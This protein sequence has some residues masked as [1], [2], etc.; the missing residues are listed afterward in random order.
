[1]STPDSAALGY[2]DAAF[3]VSV[4]ASW[5]DLAHDDEGIA[6]VYETAAAIEPYSV[7]AAAPTTCRPTSPRP[8]ARRLRPRLIR[9]PPIPQIPLRPGKRPAPQPERPA[10]GLAS[11]STPSQKSLRATANSSLADDA[12]LMLVLRA[13]GRPEP[14]PR[15]LRGEHQAAIVLRQQ[16]GQ[17]ELRQ[18]FAD[19]LGALD[20][21]LPDP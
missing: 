15:N 1:M 16:H 20:V 3:N 17:V 6:W 4:M 10:G 7:S 5:T 21:R 14:R 12:R 2:R 8:R 13:P 19:R 9:P 18:Q 11:L